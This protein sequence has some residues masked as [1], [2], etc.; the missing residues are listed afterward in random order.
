M[1]PRVTR[2]PSAMR[3]GCCSRKCLSKFYSKPYYKQQPDGLHRLDIS[4]LTCCILTMRSLALLF[5]VFPTFAE[6][7][8]VCID[9]PVIGADPETP[10]ELVQV[11]EEATASLER[12]PSL[13]AALEEQSPKLCLSSKM[14]NAHGYLDIEQNRI[15][16]S[17]QI[18][19]AMQ[20]GVLFHEI[21][22]LEQFALGICPSDD[23]AMKEYARATFALEAD[24]SVV[25]L[26]VAWD[27]KENGN[28]GP[29]LA[30]S[31][32]PTQADIA[33]KFALEMLASGDVLSAASAAF[34]QW[35]MSEVRR[36][37]YYIASCSG[38]L[39]RQDAS[40]LIPRY[41]LVPADFLNDLCR[42][43]SGSRYQCSPPEVESR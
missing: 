35:Y 7:I 29:W 19:K 20:V 14:G 39:D 17:D 43:P 8:E 6:A 4:L 11:Y 9:I 23:L 15:Y 30:L 34:A 21:R 22:H 40:K 36:E 12:F 3:M 10:A 42:L 25:S 13:L 41:Q 16:L 38:Y 33:S 5:F 1:C 31:A 18:P 24:A 2:S 32:W 37:A 26:L 27:M 28:S